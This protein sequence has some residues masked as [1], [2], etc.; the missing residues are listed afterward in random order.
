MR[1]LVVA[2]W[3][4]RGLISVRWTPKFN[5]SWTGRDILEEA[6]K[7]G[8]REMATIA[9][10]DVPPEVLKPV[11]GWVDESLESCS[12]DYTMVSEGPAV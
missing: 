1:G 5:K 8:P 3:L 2:Y 9:A 4:R 12:I 6:C 7:N 10:P 11:C